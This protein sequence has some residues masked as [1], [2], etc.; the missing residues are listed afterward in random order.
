ML[1]IVFSKVSQWFGE[2]GVSY[3][4]HFLVTQVLGT[5]CVNNCVG[6]RETNISENTSRVHLEC[7]LRLCTSSVHSG[8]A[9]WRCTLEVH[10]R[11]AQWRCTLEVHSYTLQSS[12]VGA[13][14]CVYSALRGVVHL[15]KLYSVQ[16][17]KWCGCTYI[18]FTVY[19]AVNGYRVYIAQ[20]AYRD[21]IS[22]VTCSAM[23]CVCVKSYVLC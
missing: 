19:S 3:N 2:G 13:Q 7:A 15:Y 12:T 5:T 17:C 14:F 1:N 18:Y 10:T 8:G 21:L 9:H 20:Y 22:A 23:V 16:C 4:R 11:G 6:G